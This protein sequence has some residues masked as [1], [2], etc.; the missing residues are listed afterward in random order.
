MT[1]TA[2]AGQVATA[3]AE[4]KRFE[5]LRALL[6]LHSGHAVYQLADGGF[7]VAWKALS[8]ECRDL[9][10]LEAHARRVGAMR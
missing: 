9:A 3:D 2:D 10:E 1:P 5:H 4:R 7:L 6:A 8:R